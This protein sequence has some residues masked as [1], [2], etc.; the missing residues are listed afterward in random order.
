MRGFS[1]FVKYAR[2]DERGSIAIL[3]SFSVFIL[4]LCTGLAIDGARAYN[5]SS[6]LMAALDAASL[7]AGTMLDDPD[8]TDAEIKDRAAQYFAHNWARAPITGITIDT[9]ATD[10]SRSQFSVTV[11]VNVD[12]KTTFGQLAGID[13]FSF[14]RS[15]TVV[16]RIKKVEL[17]LA[18]D[19]TGSMCMPCDKID[20][21]KQAAKDLVGIMLDG[22]HPPNTMKVALAPYAASVNAGGLAAAVSGGAS[23]DNCVVERD[24]GSTHTDTFPSGFDRLGAVS[25]VPANGRYSCPSS[26]VVPLS[27]NRDALRAA[28]DA[29]STNGATAGHLGTAWGWYLL[30]PKWS[31]LF[32]RGS[33]PRAYADTSSIKSVLI[34]TD[35]AFNTSYLPIG[36]NSTDHLTAGSSPNQTLQLC[37]NMKLQN[38]EVFTVS[39]QAEPMAQDLLRDCATDAGHYFNANSTSDLRDAFRAVAN[40]LTSLRL[41]N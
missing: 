1:H 25:T 21:L 31:S 13:K 29:M 26:P 4:V 8:Y 20:G 11:T 35:G 36:Q 2:Q 27:E 12:V 10:I 22:S 24:T 9:P 40:R 5:V 18:L 32:P 14:A 41:A 19:I 15:S 37:T 34:M 30:S 3:F 6:R 7:A 23:T 28:I 17:A 33:R 16:Y 39:F 38:I